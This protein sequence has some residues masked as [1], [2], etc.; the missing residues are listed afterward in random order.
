M[1]MWAW[2]FQVR[3]MDRLPLVGRCGESPYAHVFSFDR[4]RLKGTYLGP[5]K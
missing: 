4:V 1:A 5:D 2:R 3:F